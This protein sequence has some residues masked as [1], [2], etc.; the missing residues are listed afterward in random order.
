MNGRGMP[1]T[2]INPATIPTLIRICESSNAA[3]PIQ[4]Y[5]PNRSGAVCAFCT[6]RIL[7]V[8]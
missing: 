5:I 2:G 8:F 7:M 1:V 4:M 6:M 3:T